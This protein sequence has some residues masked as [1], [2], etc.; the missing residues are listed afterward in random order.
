MIRKKPAALNMKA[1]GL[2]GYW[3][4]KRQIRINNKEKYNSALFAGIYSLFFI[5]SYLLF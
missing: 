5:L 4:V 1:A 2:N 3:I